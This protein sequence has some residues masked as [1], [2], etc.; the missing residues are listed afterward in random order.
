MKNSTI[1]RMLSIIIPSYKEEELQQ[2]IDSLLENAEGEI[3]VIVVLDGYWPDSKLKDDS[4]LKL[5]HK[6]KNIGMRSAINSGVAM[7]KG[8]FIMKT[9]AHCMFGKDYDTTLTN[10]LGYK[11]LVVPRRY[12]LD[13]EKWKVMENERPIDYEK[14]VILQSRNKFHGQEWPSRAKNRRDITVDENMI[15]QGSCWVTMRESWNDLVGE[16]DVENYGQFCQE[17]LEIAMN[18]W[19]KGGRVL[20]NK[21]AWYAHKHRKFGR[22]HNINRDEQD[23]G[24][25]YGLKKWMKEFEK[26]EERFG[27][28]ESNEKD[29]EFSKYKKWG[30]YHWEQYKKLFKYKKHA[31]KVKKWVKEKRV[32]DIG[33]GDGLITSLV[34]A[35]GIDNEPEAVK[36]ANEKGV[37]VFEGNGYSINFPDNFFESAMMIDVL[38]HFKNP[39]KALK[40]A[41]R[42]I[43]KYLYICTPPKRDDGK[44]TDKF[45]FQEW[46]DKELKELVENEGFKL[47][48]KIEVNKKDK[49]MYAKFRKK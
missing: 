40:E 9:D 12:K 30:A 47:E 27:L 32:L 17:P 33:A 24:N 45:H 36:L 5:L 15:F 49:F 23:K 16:L 7:A 38:E 21:R 10:N 35:V 3:E 29:V 20:V 44:L 42:V 22:T 4:R 11:E 14:L 25:E 6:G 28:R 19:S 37:H 31:N 26:L 43:E 34:G 8:E 2:T 48:G 46:T 39:R 1:T 18:F 41:K 13:T